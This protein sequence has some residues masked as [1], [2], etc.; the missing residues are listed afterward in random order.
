MKRTFHTEAIQNN[1]KNPKYASILDIRKYILFPKDN[2]VTATLFANDLYEDYLYKFLDLNQVDITG[3]NV[4]DV[5]GNNGQISIEFAHL[6]GD[7]GKIFT[8]EPQ[9]IIYQQLC[10]NIFIN[11]LDNVWVYNIAIGSENGITTIEKP[12]YFDQSFVNFGNVHVGVQENY[13]VVEV[14]TL[15]SFDLKNISI[16]KI[17]VQGFEKKVLMGAK[18][19]IQ[20]N[21]PIIY[22][23]IE[24]EQLKLYGDSEYSVFELLSEM[25][26]SYT[27]FNDGKPYQTD[28][29]LCLDFVALP[30][31]KIGEKD[32]KT[33]FD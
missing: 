14:R 24:E 18:E 1:R 22:I 8:F 28:S 15:D 30:N 13:E 10:G 2:A 32:W 20:N 21:R 6:V 26:Y 9:R 17:D 23:E 31:E 29:G 11:G 3:T 19:T 33:S 5:G 27:R 4:I 25:G 7:T 12:N 16:I